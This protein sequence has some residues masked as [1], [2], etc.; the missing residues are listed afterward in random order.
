MRELLNDEEQKE[1]Y[2]KLL[3]DIE[4]YMDSFT[5]I[6]EKGEFDIVFAIF[7]LLL[8]D[9]GATF[10]YDPYERPSSSKIEKPI[11]ELIEDSEDLKKA[12]KHI[13]ELV[14]AINEGTKKF[15]YSEAPFLHEAMSKHFEYE[16][17]LTLDDLCP[18]EKYYPYDDEDE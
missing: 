9:T 10:T 6:N 3:K 16:T 8:R 17:G 13:E 11:K 4:P 14:Q 15:S 2:N 12:E 18:A 5:G 7:S 1:L